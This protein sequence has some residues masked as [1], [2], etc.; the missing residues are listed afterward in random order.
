MKDR[1]GLFQVSETTCIWM[2]FI[3]TQLFHYSVQANVL[4]GYVYFFQGAK[5]SELHDK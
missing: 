4:L 2:F 5:K 1:K 3:A